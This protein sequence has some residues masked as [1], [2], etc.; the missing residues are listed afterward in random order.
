MRVCRLVHGALVVTHTVSTARLATPS[1]TMLVLVVRG[2]VE[3]EG[4]TPYT[5][6]KPRQ[7]DTWD[8]SRIQVTAEIYPYLL[9]MA[10]RIPSPP[11]SNPAL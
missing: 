6:L 4:V 1:A 11:A 10:I 9:I 7:V 3:Q 5:E 2:T 8:A